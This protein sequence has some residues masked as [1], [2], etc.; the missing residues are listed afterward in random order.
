MG[1]EQV[2]TPWEVEAENGVDYDK[3]IQTFGSQAISEELIARVERVTG[4]RAHHWLRKGIFFSHRD[5]KEVLDLYE[6]GKPFYLYTGRGPSSGS[7]HFGHLVPFIFTKWLQDTFNVPLV[8]QLTDDEK[9]LFKEQSKW[10]CRRGAAAGWARGG[11]GGGQARLPAGRDDLNPSYSEDYRA[12]TSSL[13]FVFR[14]YLTL[15]G[16]SARAVAG[17]RAGLGVC[18]LVRFARRAN[19]RPSFCASSSLT[20]LALAP[21]MRSL[22][23]GGRVA[24]HGVRERQGHHRGGV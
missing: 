12:D 23:S 22:S 5:L 14:S 20:Y 18:L 21:A 13:K 17:R 11:R 7:L 4:R 8:I 3:L 6:A 2:V 1:D 24:P 10:C 9:S 19:P 15:A 16:G